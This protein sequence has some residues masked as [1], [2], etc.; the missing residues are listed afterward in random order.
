MSPRPTSQL[1]A[2]VRAV[3][4]ER[5]LFDYLEDRALLV[6]LNQVMRR[7]RLERLPPDFE[8]SLDSMR[9]RVAARKN[10]LLEGT[11]VATVSSTTPTR[12]KIPVPPGNL[13]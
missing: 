11:P 12:R 13:A 10:E 8:A 7:V 5:F 1:A 6:R 3:G 4:R 9:R 2:M